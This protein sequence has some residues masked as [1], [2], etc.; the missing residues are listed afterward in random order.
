MSKGGIKRFYKT[1]EVEACDGAYNVLLDGR[2]LKTPGKTLLQAGTHALAKAI[3]D[4]WEAQQADVVPDSMPLTK[5][6][7]TAIDRVGPN[8]GAV[9]DELANYGA[10]DLL[11]YRAESPAELVRRQAKAW[12]PCL[13]WV[14]SRYGAR[15][16]VTTGVVHIEQPVEALARLRDAIDAED[17]Y[18]LVSLHTATTITGSLVLGLALTTRTLDVAAVFNASSI[19]ADFQAEQW[20]RDAEAEAVRARRLADLEAAGRFLALLAA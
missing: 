16:R 15:L 11:C 12:D 17:I 5:A 7:N 13:D 2:T 6:L 3:A 20:G 14:D 18:R 19:D 4:E 8:R 9:V 10:T 1:V